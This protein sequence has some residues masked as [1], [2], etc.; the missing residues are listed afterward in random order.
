MIFNYF[1]I[2]NLVK[3]NKN[4]VEL[5]K[6]SQ[7]STVKIKGFFREKDCF[8][9]DDVNWR[10][11]GV[12][13]DKTDEFYVI[14]TNLHVIG[15]WQIYDSDLLTPEIDEYSLDI[16][17][18]NSNDWVSVR[19]ILVNAKLKDFALIY[20]KTAAD[21]PILP[22]SRQKPRQGMNVYAMGHPS[23]LDFTFTAGVI[24]GLRETRSDLEVPYQLIQTDTVLNPGNSGGPLLDE[25][26]QLIGI[27]VSKVSQ[28]CGLNFAIPA[29]EIIA[30][31]EHEEFVEFP[32]VPAQ[33]GLFVEQLKQG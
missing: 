29:Q 2:N 31:F 17:T 4:P 13:I 21:Y 33:I 12:I 18:V 15:F 1:F 30:S 6:I 10:G 11:A 7:D 20:I 24:S 8:L 5:A 32:L 19:K 9:N 25:K 22:L 27:V 23:G 26:G 28:K 16:Q 14:L 3:A